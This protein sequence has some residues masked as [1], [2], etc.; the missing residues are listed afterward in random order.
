MF[1]NLREIPYSEAV[2]LEHKPSIKDKERYLMQRITVEKIMR[3]LFRRKGGNP[4][5]KYAHYFSVNQYTKLISFY[6]YPCVVKIPISCFDKDKISFTFGDSFYAFFVFSHLTKR[7]LY[8][9]NE[10]DDMMK[11]YP[12]DKYM[13][14]IEMRLWDNPER[15]SKYMVKDDTLHLHSLQLTYENI[16]TNKLKFEYIKYC[17][18]IN[19]EHYFSAEGIHG[20]N[21]IKRVL[22]HCIIL[23]QLNNLSEEQKKHS[24]FICS[25]S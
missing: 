21:Y 3:S 18:L 20:I 9:V 11:R 7:K 12:I 4:Q 2:L 23:A 25:L 19:P 13:K 17:R 1:T 5:L 15:Y 10:M 8:M 14:Y 22:I 24:F 16:F 6:N